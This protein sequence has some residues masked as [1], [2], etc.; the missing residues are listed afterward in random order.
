[1]SLLRLKKTETNQY[2][3]IRQCEVTHVLVGYYIDNA[4]LYADGNNR[5]LMQQAVNVLLLPLP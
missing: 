1:M 4:V 3:Q 2:L 5:L